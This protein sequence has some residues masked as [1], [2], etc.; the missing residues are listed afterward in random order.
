M[1]ACP[2]NRG[3]AGGVCEICGARVDEQERPGH[4]RPFAPLDRSREPAR[5]AP[6]SAPRPSGTRAESDRSS[7]LSRPAS[8]P[9]RAPVPGP[10]DPQWRD[11]LASLFGPAEP[12]SPRHPE[13]EPAE[14]A[15]K[16]TRAPRPPLDLSATTPDLFRISPPTRP[17]RALSSAPPPMPPAPV[18]PAPVR[19]PASPDPGRAPASPDPAPAPASPTAA[20]AAAAPSAPPDPPAPQPGVTAWSVLVACDRVYYMMRLADERFSPTLEF[21]AEPSERRIP[22]AGEEMRIGRR[23]AGRQVDPE[24]DLAGP[25]ADPGISRLHARLVRNPEGTW[26]LVDTGSANGTLLNGQ[27]VPAGEPVTLREGD[28]MHLGAWTVIVLLRG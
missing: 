4:G 13:P 17:E 14:I 26:A 23:S 12:K 11:P 24:I 19:A 3:S 8:A 5:P 27:H 2:H 22:L 10:G 21:P 9:H 6:S 7:S 25:P 28:R 20:A 15:H 16:H 1:G 18:P